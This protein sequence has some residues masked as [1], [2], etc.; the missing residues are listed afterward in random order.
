MSAVSQVQVLGLR[1]LEGLAEPF[2]AST[3]SFQELSSSLNQS[4]ARS[5]TMCAP[6]PASRKICSERAIVST[7]SHSRSTSSVLVLA[8]QGIAQSSSACT[9]C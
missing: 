1:P 5:P 4:P 7:S 6:R 3:T 8:G 9:C 2:N